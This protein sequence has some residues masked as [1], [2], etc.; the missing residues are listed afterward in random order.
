MFL[1]NN[2]KKF[3]FN[4]GKVGLIT[5]I[6]GVALLMLASFLLGIAVGKNPEYMPHFL[7]REA[8]QRLWGGQA[9]PVADGEQS[10][11]GS[12]VAEKEGD[13]DNITIDA[14]KEVIS[15]KSLTSRG[16]VT[17]ATAVQGVRAD[18]FI[19]RYGIFKERENAQKLAAS[20]AGKGIRTRYA[21]LDVPGKGN[22]TALISSDFDTEEQA[23]R[24]VR[25]ISNKIKKVRPIVLPLD[26][27]IVL[28]DE[29]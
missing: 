5:F 26:G 1:G 27:H 9:M 22:L 7:A 12:K 16:E 20:L 14:A 24:F 8:P 29:R 10:G 3:E 2:N 25:N 21:S 18:K 4:L 15:E 17:R 13:M 23:R 11:H 28:P 6:S 19:V